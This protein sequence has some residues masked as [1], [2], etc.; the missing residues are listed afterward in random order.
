M[1]YEFDDYVN[2]MRI[3]EHLR[4]QREKAAELKKQNTTSTPATP[5]QTERPRQEEETAP[6]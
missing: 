2:R 3:V 5:A 4:K 6:A 1:C